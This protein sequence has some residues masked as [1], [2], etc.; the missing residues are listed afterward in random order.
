MEW[1]TNE[2]P[3]MVGENFKNFY[4]RLDKTATYDNNILPEIK[5]CKM[6]IP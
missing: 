5:L 6:K 2:I 1:F 4:L 3:N